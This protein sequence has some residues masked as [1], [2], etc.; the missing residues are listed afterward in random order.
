V[1][2][3]A[4]TVGTT[5]K[6]FGT[7]TIM[8]VDPDIPPAVVGN[9]TSELLHWMQGGLVSASTATTIGGVQI[10]ELVNTKNQSAFA[11][12]LGPSPPA[13]APLTHRY[14]QLLLNT[15]GNT[16]AVSSLSKFAAVRTNFSAV[17]VVQSS[18]AVLVAGNS[19]N[20]T[21]TTGTAIATGTSTGSTPS[22]TPFQ[23]NSGGAEQIK[24][25][26]FIAGFGAMVATAMML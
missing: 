20:V 21:N 11:S 8:M 23:Q 14:T 17:N 3:T 18:G 5:E 22:S 9:P 2:A 1:T 19:F 25:G 15:T 4:P 26:V 10:F 13:K 16:N 6:L 7:Y 24:S 12:Y